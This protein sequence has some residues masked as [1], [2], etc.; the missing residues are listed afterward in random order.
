MA[1]R[2]RATPQLPFGTTALGGPGIRIGTERAADDDRLRKLA[3][4]EAAVADLGRRAL[5]GAETEELMQAAVETAVSMLG[6]DLA[7]V[8]ELR[9]DSDD[10]DLRATVGF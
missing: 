2:P 6:V 7:A 3:R 1:A 5:E 8:F 4:A 9:P 10:L